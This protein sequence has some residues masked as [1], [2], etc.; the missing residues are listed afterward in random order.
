MRACTVAAALRV[1]VC[2]CVLV[3]CGCCRVTR[4]RRP[5]QTSCPP[6]AAMRS[7][8]K[9]SWR[10]Q[11]GLSAVAS[12]HTH[13]GVTRDVLRHAALVVYHSATACGC[14][15]LSCSSRT[16]CHCVVVVKSFRAQPRGSVMH[17][18]FTHMQVNSQH[19]SSVPPSSTKMMTPLLAHRNASCA[20]PPRCLPPCTVP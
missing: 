17:K 15:C 14:A 10:W 13:S 3:P 12:Q 6:R 7:E 18:E 4:P 16:P 20:K 2:V 19:T 1:L 8:C 11:N 9:W 5:R